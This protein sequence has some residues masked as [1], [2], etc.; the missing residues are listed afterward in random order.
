MNLQE[1]WSTEC[2][3]GLKNKASGLQ[4]LPL[5]ENDFEMTGEE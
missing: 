5:V 1:I 4:K 2:C 3:Y